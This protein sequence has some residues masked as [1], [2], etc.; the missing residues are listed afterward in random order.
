MTKHPTW[1][2]I[3]KDVS[4]CNN[5]YEVLEVAGLDY[6]V[7][8]TQ[9]YYNSSD[10]KLIPTDSKQAVIRADNGRLYGFVSPRYKVIQNHEAFAVIDKMDID[11]KYVRAGETHTGVN[12]IIIALTPVSINQNDVLPHIIFQNGHSGEISLRASICALRVLGQTQLNLELPT[13]NVVNVKHYSNV[14]ISG[15][16]EILKRSMEYMSDLDKL[17]TRLF[18][19]RLSTTDVYNAIREMFPI[20]A[21]TPVKLAKGLEQRQMEVQLA[22]DSPDNDTIRGTAWGLVCAYMDALT[23]S[24]PVR[25][26][27]GWHDNHFVNMTLSSKQTPLSDILK[28]I[29]F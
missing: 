8:K 12:F 29:D 19:V 27:A 1:A 26:T 15:G 2:K 10:K 24:S 17:A 11:F 25:T 14:G 21:K 16:K 18:G 3:G 20:N 9:M 23:Q 7:V 6:N 4:E 22:Y 13:S 5:V 28:G